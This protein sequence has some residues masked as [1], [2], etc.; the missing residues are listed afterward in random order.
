MLNTGGDEL[1]RVVF[2]APNDFD[3]MKDGWIETKDE[4]DETEK[5]ELH[6]GVGRL[7]APFDCEIRMRTRGKERLSSRAHLLYSQL[8]SQPQSHTSSDQS[9]TELSQLQTNPVRKKTRIHIQ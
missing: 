1:R 8:F 3:M 6:I 7:C 4:Q 9:M 2:D 5:V